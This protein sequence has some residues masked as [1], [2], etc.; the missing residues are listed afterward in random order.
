MLQEKKCQETRDQLFR[1]VL[2]GLAVI[3]FIS[4]LLPQEASNFGAS[5]QSSKLF[6]L[7]RESNRRTSITKTQRKRKPLKSPLL[8]RIHPTVLDRILIINSDADD[9]SSHAEPKSDRNHNQHGFLDGDQGMSIA[10]VGGDSAKTIIRNITRVQK[11]KSG[12]RLRIKDMDTSYDKILTRL[13]TGE[14]KLTVDNRKYF[15][16]TY[17]RRR[18]RRRRQRQSLDLPAENENEEPITYYGWL[19]L[20]PIFTPVQHHLTRYDLLNSTKRN[21]I[22]LRVIDASRNGII[23]LLSFSTQPTVTLMILLGFCFVCF[24]LVFAKFCLKF[25]SKRTEIDA[26]CK[27]CSVGK[28]YSQPS[29]PSSKRKKKRNRLNRGTKSVKEIKDAPSLACVQAPD[30]TEDNLPYPPRN[31]LESSEDFKPSGILEAPSKKLAGGSRLCSEGTER[32]NC[33][34]IQKLKCTIPS[35][36][37][38]KTAEKKML[39]DEKVH[40]CTGEN[41]KSAHHNPNHKKIQSDKMHPSI[42]SVEND[43]NL[44]QRKTIRGAGNSELQHSRHALL[45]SSEENVWD[46]NEAICNSLCMQPLLSISPS[47][48][49]TE[50]GN[51]SSWSCSSDAS[52]ITNDP[53][54]SISSTPISDSTIFSGGCADDSSKEN[55]TKLS[56]GDP[57]LSKYSSKATRNSGTKSINTYSFSL[58]K[59]QLSSS[60]M[61]YQSPRIPTD[62]E[63]TEAYQKLKEWQ[64]KQINRIVA[65]RARSEGQKNVDQSFSNTVIDNM[66]KLKAPEFFPVQVGKDVERIFSPAVG[67]ASHN[68]WKDATN[69]K[70]DD[71]VRRCRT[72]NDTDEILCATASESLHSSCAAWHPSSFLGYS[73]TYKGVSSLCKYQT[74]HSLNK[75]GSSLSQNEDNMLFE[76]LNSAFDEVIEDDEASVLSGD[77]IALSASGDG[78]DAGKLGSVWETSAK[79]HHSSYASIWE[80][81]CDSKVKETNS[82]ECEAGVVR[83]LLELTSSNPVNVQRNDSVTTSTTY[84]S[85]SSPVVRGIFH[86]SSTN[87]ARNVW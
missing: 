70:Y 7:G 86:M 19:S 67:T 68:L 10:K 27:N 39:E 20:S 6:S 47:N 32:S 81:V 29:V 57:Y 18:R 34:L 48:V 50:I 73:E 24:A 46:S 22:T 43:V 75:M 17:M 37:V 71:S 62:E 23:R 15:S 40:T 1:V 58:S 38:K 59:G 2:M 14:R 74:T 16:S 35:I 3:F 55:M 84:K 21:R 72:I 85:P 25:D 11:E 13:Q 5:E 28:S 77:V 83:T 76:E 52:T 4:A 42:G 56:L 80:D 36:S 51:T 31:E 49:I 78:V 30:Q 33:G 63:R 61:D 64:A 8:L 53:I 69:G 26:V 82:S 12:D 60:K 79:P 44:T 9:T 41:I 87:G 66:N 65:S 45:S 54:P